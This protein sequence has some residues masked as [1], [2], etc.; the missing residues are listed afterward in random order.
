MINNDIDLKNYLRHLLFFVYT[1]RNNIENVS[2]VAF[3]S[4]ET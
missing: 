3:Y 4:D 2:L 1:Y